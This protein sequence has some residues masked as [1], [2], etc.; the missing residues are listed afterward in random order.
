VD[1]R[2]TSS[3]SS[4]QPSSL[5]VQSRCLAGYPPALNCQVQHV[6]QRRPWLQ[7][8]HVEEGL[9]GTGPDRR[10]D[11]LLLFIVGKQDDDLLAPPLPKLMRQL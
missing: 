11:R 7:A 3:Q 1:H 6:R 4:G 2:P 9:I 8:E 10:G 5:L